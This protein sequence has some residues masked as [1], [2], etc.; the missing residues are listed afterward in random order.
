VFAV[1]RG[2]AGK[3]ADVF[4]HLPIHKINI[5][6]FNSSRF[7]ITTIRSV[8]LQLTDGTHYTPKYTETG[9]RFLSVINVTESRIDFGDTKFISESEHSEL[10]KRCQPISGD[11][12]LTKVG[13][14]G[15]AC[16]V[17][18]N[19]PKF[20][21]FVSVALLKPDAKKV[22]PEYLSAYLNT[23]Y[24]FLQFER[25]LKGIGVPDLH[26]ENIA[27]TRIILPDIKIQARLC[28]HYY[29]AFQRRAAKLREADALLAGMD[30]VVLD[31]LG[32]ELKPIENRLAYAVT[33]GALGRRFDPYANQPKFTIN[34][35]ALK[36]KCNMTALSCLSS[37]IFSGITPKSGGEAYTN[38]D[39]GVPFI[40]SG[41]INSDGTV[42]T[43]VDVWLK[44]EVHNAL[45]C[46]SQ[47]ANNDILIAIVGATIG[48]VGVFKGNM[49]ANINQAIAAVRLNDKRFMPEYIVAYLHSPIGQMYLDYL[50]RPVARANI[51]LEEIGSIEIPIVS[52][53]I[54]RQIVSEC[55]R[56]V[57]NANALRSKAEAEWTAAKARFEW[58]LLS[59]GEVTNR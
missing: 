49:Q 24:A 40:R 26:L 46:N 8:L 57:A 7:N 56:I 17:P 34:F 19:S 52:I 59:T 29:E 6:S 38:A 15:R 1:K 58:A 13:S 31:H 20:S 16:V 21:L 5:D 10:I 39:L 43:D 23:K 37:S 33:L 3:R 48:K 54:Q 44:P 2:E 41:N 25:V 9:V 55:N 27:E 53:D 22:L 45:M 4:F 32:V 50:K 11:V 51:N 36:A 14:I 30:G 12:L 35:A 42:T 18:D 47:L 28:R